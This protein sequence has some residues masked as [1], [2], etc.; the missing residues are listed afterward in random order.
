MKFSKLS[1]LLPLLDRRWNYDMPWISRT[2]ILFYKQKLTRKKWGNLNKYK[3][4]KG[5]RIKRELKI[6]RDISTLLYPACRKYKNVDACNSRKIL[7]GYLQQQLLRQSQNHKNRCMFLS[8]CI[9]LNMFLICTREYAVHKNIN[10]LIT[11]GPH[12]LLCR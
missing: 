5:L 4:N 12:I 10:N 2:K 8:R 11:S 3:V 7:L 1:Q 6:S 9:L